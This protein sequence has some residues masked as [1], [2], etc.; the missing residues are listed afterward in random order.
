MALPARWGQAAKPKARQGRIGN[1]CVAGRSG[2]QG[3]LGE[4]ANKKMSNVAVKNTCKATE[5]RTGTKLDYVFGKATGRPHNI[6]RSSTVQ[7]FLD[8]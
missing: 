3:V 5:A 2:K 4:G 6:Q 8:P 1:R 7:R